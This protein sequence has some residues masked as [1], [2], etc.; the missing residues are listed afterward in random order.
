MA[1]LKY[2]SDSDRQRNASSLHRSREHARKLAESIGQDVPSPMSA[3]TNTTT[4]SFA[5]FGS[6]FASSSD[7]RAQRTTRFNTKANLRSDD[8]FGGKDPFAD[9]DLDFGQATKQ[10]GYFDQDP[11]N[12]SSRENKTRS[13]A[14]SLEKQRAAAAALAAEFTA[15]AN[16]NTR[17]NSQPSFADSPASR[18]NRMRNAS[19]TQQRQEP[20]FENNAAPFQ[21]SWPTESQ[22]M[23]TMT[24]NSSMQSSFPQQTGAK[25]PE[26]KTAIT[27]QRASPV[28]PPLSSA[29]PHGAAAR[30]RMRNHMRVGNSS[31]VGLSSSSSGASFHRSESDSAAQQTPP[32]SPHSMKRYVSSDSVGS[33]SRGKVTDRVSNYI[34][35]SSSS[36]H[37]QP[38][39]KSA[40]RSVGSATRSVTSSNS[41]TEMNLFD[42][43]HAKGTGFTF[44]AFG[45]DASQI[46]REVNEAMND[47]FAVVN[48]G[49]SIGD[50]DLSF[51]VDQDPSDDFAAGRWTDSPAVSRS[52]TPIQSASEDGFVDG[53]RVN[54]MAHLPIHV[55]QSPTSTERSSLTSESSDKHNHLQDSGR[56]NLFKQKAGFHESKQSRKIVRPADQTSR[57]SPLQP[58]KEAGSGLSPLRKSDKLLAMPVLADVSTQRVS[59]QKPERDVEFFDPDFSAD[60]TDTNSDHDAPAR[61]DV[62]FASDAGVSSDFAPSDPGTGLDILADLKSK[63]S[64][65]SSSSERTDSED[66]DVLPMEEKKED[67]TDQSANRSVGNLKSKWE[68][69]ETTRN[70]GVHPAASSHSRP[71]MANGFSRETVRHSPIVQTKPHQTEPRRSIPSAVER[72]KAS[73]PGGK[74][75]YSSRSEG[76]ATF[77]SS[78][79]NQILGNIEKASPRESDSKS[80]VGTPSPSFANV[81]LRKTAPSFAT[82]Q[83]ST[84]RDEVLEPRRAPTDES[85]DHESQGDEHMIASEFAPEPEPKLTY[86]QKRD[87]ELQA[88]REEAER[89][90]AAE[91]ESEP[92]ARDVAT[93]IKRRIAAN[94][95]NATEPMDE[96]SETQDTASS[97]RVSSMEDS[98]AAAFASQVPPSSPRRVQSDLVIKTQS[99]VSSPPLSPRHDSAVSRLLM[100]NQVET[101][102]KSPTRKARAATPEAEEHK[103]ITP[104]ATKMMLNAFLAG[105]ESISSGGDASHGRSDVQEII[106]PSESEDTAGA[107]SAA[108]GLCRVPAL[109]DDPKYEKYFKMLKIGMPMDVVKHSM[110]RDGLD[111]SVMDGDHN[112]PVGIPLKQDPKYVKYFKML[113]VGLPMEAV[114]HAMARDGLDPTVMDQDHDLPVQSGKKEVSDEP[115]EKDSHRRAR[116]H[117]KTLRKVTSNSLWA[118]IDQDEDIGNIEIDEDEF[119][120]L[121]QVDKSTEAAAPAPSSGINNPKRGAVRVIDPKRANNGGIILARLKMSHDDMADA[122]DRINEHALTA[123]QIENIIEYLPTKEERKALEAYMLEGG[124]DAA[125]KFDCLCECEKFMVSMMTVKHAKRKVRALLFKLQFQSCLEDIHKDTIAIESACDDLFNSTRLRQ[126]LGIILTFGNRLNTAGNGKRRAGAFTL[127]SLLKL[128][129]AKA[130]DKKTTFLH[131]IVLIVRRNNELLL[132]FKDDIGAVFQADK[133]YWDQCVSDLEEV[134][135]QLEN[136]RRIALYQARQAMIYRLRRKKKDDDEESLSDE[137]A[138]LSLEEEVEALRAT[139]IGLFTLSAIKYVSGLRD[140]VEETKTKFARLLEYFGEDEGTMQPHDLFNIIVSFSRDFEKAKEEVFA[141][142]KRKEREERKRQAKGKV[143]AGK[144]QRGRPPTHSPAQPERKTHQ[145]ML[146]ASNFQPSMSSVLQ[147][148]KSRS[149]SLSQPA[150]E[151]RRSPTK[152]TDPVP[153]RGTQTRINM[154]AS[155]VFRAE[156]PGSTESPMKSRTSMSENGSTRSQSL[157]PAAVSSATTRHPSDVSTSKTKAA[158]QHRMKMRQRYT[159]ERSNSSPPG[160]D[161]S[162]P[163]PSHR[164]VPHQSDESQ[165][166]T[167]YSPSPNVQAPRRSP[168]HDDDDEGTKALSPRSSMRNRMMQQKLRQKASAGV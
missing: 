128:R 1:F 46:N 31:S 107:S 92:P 148:I 149:S 32:Q 122:V 117:W 143:G 164:Q 89:T 7:S 10:N 104:K 54:K 112:R 162:S 20:S 82:K 26:R 83:D 145:P 119:Q 3:V 140:K 17:K 67:L 22:S 163:P 87:L 121:F 28:A 35:M 30:R 91:P 23:A 158:L 96:M 71:A 123:E 110:T 150:P 97:S 24:P 70:A 76:G 65:Y 78:H 99:P 11:F 134:E 75:G 57:I 85:T 15:T 58:R 100:L 165:R 102:S 132:N 62:G 25:T 33:A 40:N 139:D 69:R 127:D 135:N 136:V 141:N 37:R 63:S 124:Q 64:K 52:S 80:D 34:S 21:P 125:E 161:S 12:P 142:E 36:H 105:R 68:T 60:F 51:F 48:G 166:R 146:R 147:E 55:K 53:F 108:G 41:S 43:N 9:E 73:S 129:Q 95:K 152:K 13:K 118:Q 133:V 49:G 6:A 154:P 61:S 160:L 98:G 115:K 144:G 167:A 5:D 42:S 47:I 153:P 106:L 88:E 137:E 66:H 38:S 109:K 157:D 90:Q 113:A 44:D 2:G 94:K 130:F 126:L 155:G 101:T 86:R 103:S 120:E 84:T 156:I 27:T 8:P 72:M 138:S 50:P 168:S 56:I 45:L 151:A 14:P 59:K 16:I 18:R 77:K 116:L 29:E 39:P 114:K 79:V 19:S 74:L 93:L 159:G 131:Y 4:N 81:K 111:P